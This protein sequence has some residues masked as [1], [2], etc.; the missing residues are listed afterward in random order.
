MPVPHRETEAKDP[1]QG[2]SRIRLACSAGGQE[3]AEK[4]CYDIQYSLLGSP[5][6]HNV[7]KRFGRKPKDEHPY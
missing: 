1:S 6:E 4:E 7:E 2:S 5:I 3:P